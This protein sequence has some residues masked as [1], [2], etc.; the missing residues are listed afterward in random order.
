[1]TPAPSGV[2]PRSKQ[3]A[4]LKV[5]ASDAPTSDASTV[6]TMA[7]PPRRRTGDAGYAELRRR[8]TQ[9]G[10][11][12]RRYDYYAMRF[13]TALALFVAALA[14][15]PF[16]PDGWGWTALAAVAVGFTMTQLGI[17]GHDAGH[18][19]VFR[20]AWPNWIMGQ[21]CLSLVLGT[22]FSFWRDRHNQHHVLTNDEDEDPDLELGGLFTL[23][24]DEAAKQRGLRRWATRYQAW[25]FVPTVTLLLDW[26]FRSEG[27][28]YVLTELR[29]QRRTAEAALLGLSI[30]LWA[31][32]LLVFGWRWLA[33]YVGAQWLCNLYLG[34]AF[35]PNHKGM[36]TWAG[37]T[38]HSFIERQVLSSC[39]VD[40]GRVADYL[41]CGLNYQIEHHL[42]PTMPRVNFGRALPI[43]RQFCKERELPY[44]SLSALG[45]YRQALGELDRCGRATRLFA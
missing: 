16:L 1:M 22:S 31:S 44:E 11:L 10:L 29:G 5:V 27:W 43:V 41:Y 34:L 37:G 20:R 7:S 33:I 2:L 21:F 8:V 32:P 3:D 42:F 4:A 15:V 45:A 6:A 14:T 25:L 9:A 28:R 40:P 18:L 23:N 12:D 39:N 19:A 30:V 35:A 26:A 13:V 24:A 36:P 17:L 38:K